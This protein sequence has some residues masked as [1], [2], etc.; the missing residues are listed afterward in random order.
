MSIAKNARVFGCAV[1]DLRECAL[2]FD[3]AREASA[4]NVMNNRRRNLQR[5]LLPDLASMLSKHGLEPEHLYFALGCDLKNDVDACNETA[6]QLSDLLSMMRYPRNVKRAK[7]PGQLT[8]E[9][10][11][12]AFHAWLKNRLRQN[13][14][15]LRAVA[16]QL[17]VSHSAV[18]K[19]GLG[20][21]QSRRIQVALAKAVGDD[22]EDLFRHHNTYAGAA[23][24]VSG[25]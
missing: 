13:G 6:G 14:S 17:G 16:K 25:N 23:S 19:V 22:P 10:D 5:R 20:Q 12:R 8:S 18:S 1:F 3:V 2:Y 4:K 11:F 24:E 7:V 9:E 15:S 21:R